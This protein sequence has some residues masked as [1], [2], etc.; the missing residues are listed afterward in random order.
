MLGGSDV[1]AH[2]AQQTSN[3]NDDGGT[4]VILTMLVFVVTFLALFF[5]TNLTIFGSL[6]ISIGLT[7]VICVPCFAWRRQRQKKML[8]L[9]SQEQ[10]KQLKQQREASQT[11]PK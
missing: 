1:A 10:L 5:F 8:K 3:I 2:S 9:L 11:P 6:V 7:V 4:P